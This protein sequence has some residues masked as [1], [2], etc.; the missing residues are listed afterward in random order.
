M[1]ETQMHLM[2]HHR[3]IDE[4]EYKPETNQISYLAINL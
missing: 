3:A 2:P 4:V 1:V